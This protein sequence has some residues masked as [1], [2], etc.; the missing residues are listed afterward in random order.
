MNDSIRAVLFDAG[1]TLI[2]SMPDVAGIYCEAARRCGATIAPQHVHRILP[3]LLN[4]YA[5]TTREAARTAVTDEA[6][7]EMWR[8]VTYPVYEALGELHTVD[9]DVW[10]DQLHEMFVD[11]DTWQPYE[12]TIDVLH[13]LRSMGLRTA[14]V[15]NWSSNLPHILEAK[16]LTPYFDAVVVSCLE[17]VRKPDPGIFRRALWS[18]GVR[19]EQAVHVGDSYEDDVRGARQAGIR[20]V[21]VSRSSQAPRDCAVISDLRGLLP[22][23][24][25]HRAG[26]GDG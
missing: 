6:D 8:S 24:L 5:E 1:H 22:L 9:Y 26:S 23:V 17:G 7:K 13:E 20:P 21:L 25:D 11:P 19:P 18:T 10:F 16:G 4:K 12:E 3:L 15:S 2:E 14:V